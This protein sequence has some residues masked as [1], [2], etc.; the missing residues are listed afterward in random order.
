VN[1]VPTGYK[2]KSMRR[3]FRSSPATWCATAL[4][5]LALLIRLVPFGWY[6][7]PDEPIWVLRSVRLLDAFTQGDW[8]AIPQTG[9]PGYTTMILGAIGVQLATWIQPA[10]SFEHLAYIRDIAWLAPESSPAFPHLAFF[11][12][13]CRS[14]VALVCASGIALIYTTGRRRFGERT[15]RLLALFLA[16]DPFFA[17]HAGLLH[18]DALQATFV[19]V[20]IIYILPHET[21][22][23]NVSSIIASAFFL[24]LAGLTKT[25]G[26]LIAPGLV[27]VIV[28]LGT[29]TFRQRCLRVSALGLF[30][31]ISMFIIFPPLWFEPIAAIE[32]LWG[33]FAYHQDAGL[34]NVFFLGQQHVNPGPFFYPVVILFRL[35]APVFV[36]LLSGVW[37]SQKSRHPYVKWFIIPIVIYIVALSIATKKFDR[38]AL[39]VIPLLTVIASLQWQP[40]VNRWKTLLLASLCLP[41][42]LVAL[43]PLYY[44]NPLLGG[45][46]VAQYIIP[47]GW[48]EGSGFAAHR[49]NNTYAKPEEHSVLTGDIPGVASI[50]RGQVLPKQAAYA[51]C[52]DA[53]L[54]RTPPEFAGYHAVKA[55]AIAGL[56]LT[57]IYTQ[58]YAFPADPYL[59]SGPIAGA[60]VNAVAPLT[61]TAALRLWVNNRFSELPFK[62]IHAADCDPI[63]E[64]QLIALLCPV[65]AN[66]DPCYCTPAGMT[67]GFQ[68]DQCQFVQLPEH[69]VDFIIRVGE[70]LD[71]V[72]ATWAPSV[73]P[74]GTLDVYLRW[75]I[76][77]PYD[78]LNVYLALR[79]SE[80]LIWAEGRTILSSR[81]DWLKSTRSPGSLLDGQVSMPLLPSL[82][83]GN[84][85]LTLGFSDNEN[86]GVG[87]TNPDGTFGGVRTNLGAV[88]IIS[89]P[90][91]QAES[92]LPLPKDVSFAGL[93]LRAAEPPPA[94]LY[95]GDPL[96]FRL[97]IARTEQTLSKSITWAVLCD[98]II[99]SQGDLLAVPGNPEG[100]EVGHYYELR[101]AP[102]TESALS[103]ADC[104]LV[105]KSANQ[106]IATIGS[107]H[108]R[109]RERSFSLPQTPQVN[110][111]F[112]IGSF[113]ELIGVDIPQPVVTQDSTLPVTLYWQARG[114]ALLNYTVFVHLVGKDG[115]IWAQSDAAPAEGNAPTAT[116]LAGQII[117]D[118]HHLDVI[119]SV[120]S[121]EYA[122]YTGLYDAQSG[123]RE[124]IWNA[125]G[126]R[127]G[128]DQ[129]PIGKI[130]ITE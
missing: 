94:I 119:E 22:Q 3:W 4:F 45:P 53:L 14:L 100:W 95:A 37:T 31:A 86:R 60:N 46:W 16:L 84:Y 69:P 54:S 106:V 47:Y 93:H 104:T 27:T 28:L 117:V 50:Y 68:V 38:Y 7:T 76:H 64:A 82:P 129:I 33:A 98:D 61:T 91:V 2:D 96:P 67:A 24:A 29:G 39:S 109:A 101:Y 79:D 1:H 23:D 73:Q 43:I 71:I 70:F 65:D 25:L 48:G 21:R 103:D 112:S 123:Y 127:V 126:E 19:I 12:N 13:T 57:S 17:G 72:A 66:K 77:S 6:V 11:L 107:F 125:K 121:G 26:L 115:K 113:G 51:M 92:A 110:L 8:T 118:I 102:R 42:A 30:T 99:Q 111:D 116:W 63:T 120:P 74:P 78:N 20:S 35:T 44:A 10:A 5:V 97:E 58:T 90:V 89:L 128:E 114:A 75:V 87:L 88:T 80:G 122:L 81:Y 32:R 59:V 62:W 9:H 85:T 124:T 40:Y 105:L 15:S 55:I 34:R 52:A 18:T 36:G 130:F 108:I 83:P 56:H 41:W 49:L